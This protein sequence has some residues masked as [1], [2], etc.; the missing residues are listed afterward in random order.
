MVRSIMLY[1][2]IDSNFVKATVQF[3]SVLRLLP[4]LIF[5]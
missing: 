4:Q 2:V 3:F 5:G 1:T